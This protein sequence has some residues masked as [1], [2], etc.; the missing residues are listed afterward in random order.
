[1]SAG[2]LAGRGIVKRLNMELVKA[3]SLL[4]PR[5]V[6]YMVLID[7]GVLVILNSQMIHTAVLFVTASMF[8]IT[9]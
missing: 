2:L 9:N 7:Q 6:F 3:M 8:L 4:I 5:D 1:M